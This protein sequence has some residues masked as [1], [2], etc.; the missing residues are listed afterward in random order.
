MYCSGCGLA[1]EPGQ[2]ICPQCGRAAA[3]AATA[4][5][6]VPAVPG[7]QFE[8]ARYAGKVRVLGI[9]WL[10]FGGLYLIMMFAW[11]TAGSWFLGSPYGPFHHEPMPPAWLTGVAWQFRWISLTVHTVLYGVAG[12]GLLQRA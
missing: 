12:W 7:F 3:P 8:V 6:A 4:V 1:L 2:T 10:V 9:L 5:P 11:Q